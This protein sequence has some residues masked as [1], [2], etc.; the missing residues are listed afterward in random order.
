VRHVRHSSPLLVVLLALALVAAACGGGGSSNKASSNSGSNAN[1]PAGGTLVVGAEQEPDCMD[2]IGSCSGSSWGYWIANV[3]TTP[4]TYN[5][6]K[7]GNGWG[8]QPSNLITGE[9][10]LKTSPQQVVT[11]HI[12]PQAK[13]SDGQPIT[14]TDF[15]YMF[16]QIT[17]GSD[18]YDTTGYSDIQSVD[19]S[20]PSTP[21][22]TFKTNFA[23][24][25]SLFGGQYGLMPSHLLQ[26]QDRDKATADGYTWS[27][28]PW[29]M[30]QGGWEKGT[31][32]TLV[33]NPNYWGTKPKL[34]KIVY[35]FITDTSAEFQAFKANETMIIYPQPQPDAVDQ[36]KAGVPGVNEYFT[37]QTGNLEALW[38]NN[39]KAPFDDVKVRQAWGYALDRTAIVNRLFGPLG[40]KNPMNTINPTILAAFA[41]PTAWAK[42]KLD[43]GMVNQLMT[44]AGWTKGSDGVWA[45]N[46]Q[47]FTAELRTT[48]G[49]KRR[50]L[51]EQIVQQQ[52]QAAGFPITV[53]NAKAG[54]LFGSILPKGDYQVALYAQVLTSYSPSNCSIQCSNNIPTAANKFSGQNWSRINDPQLTTLY[55]KVDTDLNESSREA[56]NKQADPIGANDN[57][58]LPVDPLPNILL[59]SKKIAGP[60]G[61]NPIMGPF[62]NSNLWGLNK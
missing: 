27:G 48:T 50:E 26:G 38:F 10:D 5:V 37:D 30:P 33:P 60:V 12:N 51:T 62:F 29:M 23:D 4:R 53:N 46:G 6:V 43:L 47:K 11:Y 2:W 61:D 9:A 18:I 49:N 41:D 16:E 55:T 57:V 22:V 7:V 32:L 31:Q 40:V 3:E 15:K 21:V 20:N 24:W 36:V 52:L 28:G 8:Y 19:D 56:A 14:A 17:T 58:A 42:Y 39:G 25:K 35:K 34:D 59:W 13:W 45:K 44:S 1:V 54:D